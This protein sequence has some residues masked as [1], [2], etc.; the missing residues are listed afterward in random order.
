M[1]VFCS[2]LV[3]II[4]QPILLATFFLVHQCL[5][6][7]IFWSPS[8][9]QS[10]AAALQNGFTHGALQ[11]LQESYWASKENQTANSRSWFI[12]WVLTFA[13]QLLEGSPSQGA[14]NLQPFWDNCRCDELVVGHFF[15]Q[16]VI[17]GL[18]KQDKVV[19]LVS[20]FPLGPLL[21]RKRKKKYP[22]KPSCKQEQKWN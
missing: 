15:A 1:Q 13:E 19:Q 2:H 16:F 9:M 8:E 14:S 5:C 12:Y 18:V 7:S 4:S 17:S 10:K 3:A 21:L 6:C 20:H 11:M 22:P